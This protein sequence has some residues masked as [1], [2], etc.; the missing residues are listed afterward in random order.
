MNPSLEISPLLHFRVY[1]C[2]HTK[3]S[4]RQHE[5]IFCLLLLS[6]PSPTPFSCH[7]YSAFSSVYRLSPLALGLR[8]LSGV[9]GGEAYKVAGVGE[10]ATDFKPPPALI[11]SLTEC[12]CK[13]LCDEDESRATSESM[14]NYQDTIMNM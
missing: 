11:S 13:H 14:R 3:P 2:V 10:L 5:H 6:V 12:G 8:F 1:P 7:L 9:D 4:Q